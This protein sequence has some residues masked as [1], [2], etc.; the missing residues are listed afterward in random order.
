M[1]VNKISQPYKSYSSIINSIRIIQYANKNTQSYEHDQCSF[2]K[3]NKWRLGQVKVVRKYLT[4][5]IYSKKAVRTMIKTTN[6]L[7]FIVHFHKYMK[8]EG[9]F[10]GCLNLFV[11]KVQ[12]VTRQQEYWKNCFHWFVKIFWI[13]S[14]ETVQ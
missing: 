8:N 2:N 14:T 10:R 3:H 13:H 4:L 11:K 7:A 12:N 5:R 1:P 6:L 9:C